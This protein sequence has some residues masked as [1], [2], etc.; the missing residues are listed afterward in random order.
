MTSPL[1]TNAKQLIIIDSQVIDWQSLIV[2]LSPDAAILILDPTRDGVSQIAEAVANYSNL[3]AIHIISHGS[4]GSLSLGSSVLDNSNIAVYASQL[5]S[6]GNAL[7]TNGDILLYVCNVAQGDSGIAFINE[8]A[9]FTGANIAASANLIGDAAQGG[10][11]ELE[12]QTGLIQAS[13]P[14]SHTVMTNYAHTLA[15]NSLPNGSVRIFGTKIQGAILTASPDFTDADG[16]GVITYQW[17]AN[18]VDI[19][20]AISSTYTLTQAE[21]GKAITVVAH[22][23]DGAIPPNAES[24]GSLATELIGNI[25]D[26][27]IGTVSIS[28]TPT[29]GQILTAINNLSDADG[30]GTISYQWKAGGTNIVGATNSTYTITQAEVGNTITVVAS[31]IDGQGT[32]E[33]VKSTPTSAVINVNDLPT[34]V[35]T[36]A[37]NATQGQVL[38]VSNNLADLD[39]LGSITYQWKANGININGAIGSSYTLTQAEVSKAIT[40]VASYFDGLGT[41]ESK[42]SAA[43]GAVVNV[44]DAPVGSVIITGSPT[45]GQTLTASHNLTDI[46]GLGTITYQWQATTSGG[47]AVNIAGATNATY[48]LSQADVGKTI[49]VVA[50]YTDLQNTAESKSSAPTTA[51]INVNDAP[52]GTVT[53][54]GIALQ[55][56]TLI[57]SNNV[58]DIDGIGAGAIT[59]QGQA[60]GSNI[61]G[62]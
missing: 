61:G 51:V 14:I 23:I 9:F 25:N 1:T 32:A 13:L 59:Y 34:G 18:G 46:D 48:S 53:I 43:T 40:V 29:Q 17:Q 11:W 44:N 6:I 27:P 55:G 12:Q 36:I 10:T 3:D 54:A 38:T 5:V 33:S 60:D 57:A 28:G 8:L 19:I 52:T 4:A 7:T 20:G 39:G 47:T 37:G 24:V 30:L 62:A 2:G 26:D 16:V 35:V 31:Y 45:Q 15:A 41:A 49:T 56:N 42:T 50:S 58:V 22:Y 21:V